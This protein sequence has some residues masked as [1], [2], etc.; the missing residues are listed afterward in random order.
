MQ[1]YAGRG[2]G[3]DAEL[4]EESPGTALQVRGF[5]GGQGCDV[6]LQTF[7]RFLG[8]HIWGSRLLSLAFWASE[9]VLEVLEQWPRLSKKGSVGI[10]M[11]GSRRFGLRGGI[12]GFALGHGG[13]GGL[14]FNEVSRI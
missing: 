7:R 8:I 13:L 9:P 11:G 6:Y 4:I 1:P 12:T 14:N 3:E 2:F 10:L 5:G